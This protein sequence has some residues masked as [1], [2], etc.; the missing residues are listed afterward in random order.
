MTCLRRELTGCGFKGIHGPA[1]KGEQARSV[2]DISKIRHDI[3][4][5]PRVGLE[6]GLK[7]TADFFRDELTRGT[8]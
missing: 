5:E 2:V 3:G 8:H 1:K 7:R 4:W 6:E